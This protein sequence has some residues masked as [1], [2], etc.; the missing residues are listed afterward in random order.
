MTRIHQQA[1]PT[2]TSVDPQETAPQKLGTIVMSK[3]ERAE[4]FI[5]RWKN[6]AMR[7]GFEDTALVDRL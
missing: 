6:V 1:G 7:T 5:T 3:N 4:D 2:S